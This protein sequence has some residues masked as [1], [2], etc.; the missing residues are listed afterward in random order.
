MGYQ[1]EACVF[2]EGGKRA[3][4]HGPDR[5]LFCDVARLQEAFLH[6]AS[7]IALTKRYSR[8]GPAARAKA[9]TRIEHEGYRRWLQNTGASK[10]VKPGQGDAPAAKQVAGKNV[11]M[12]MKFRA[13][14]V[15]W[16][17]VLEQRA[18]P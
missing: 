13:A 7:S 16:D 6:P 18:Q 17:E 5:C 14:K 3:R 4:P 15:A 2:G 10:E 9:L 8:L 12:P 11:S 1:D